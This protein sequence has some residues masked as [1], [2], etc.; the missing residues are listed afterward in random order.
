MTR[1][2]WGVMRTLHLGILFI[3]LLVLLHTHRKIST[4]RDIEESREI[5]E[6]RGQPTK[7][8]ITSPKNCSNSKE[9][10]NYRRA[11]PHGTDPTNPNPVIHITSLTVI[12]P[13]NWHWMAEGTH[14]FARHCPNLRPWMRCRY[15]QNA[16]DEV[17]RRSHALLF[18]ARH[19]TPAGGDQSSFRGI[20]TYRH[21]DQKWVFYEP[22][23][24][25]NTW[26]YADRNA[27]YWKWF[28]LTATFTM[29]SNIPYIEA[30]K[31]YSCESLLPF[32]CSLCEY[33]H[34]HRHEHQEVYDAS[35]FWSV[36][37]R[38]VD[39]RYFYKGFADNIIPNIKYDTDPSLFL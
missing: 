9:Y 30:K 24:P 20:P 14:Y 8:F 26:N 3:M 4:S 13:R 22:E 12:Q 34:H 32:P 7:P 5:Y 1:V 25:T 28:N 21:P 38:C 37:Q 29:D 6:H 10:D 11:Y 19:M 31:A 2:F 33:L 27:P 16:T 36:E 23:A 39:P 18:H 35:S 17:I 15:H